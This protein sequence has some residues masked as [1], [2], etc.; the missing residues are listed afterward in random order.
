MKTLF[1]I[2]D[3]EI[4]RF[5]QLILVIQLAVTGLVCLAIIGHPIPVLTQIVGFI[6][7]CFIP[8]AV[9]L[10]A[11]KWHRLGWVKTLLYSVGL[12]IASLMFLGLFINS[13]YP[14]I[15]I[16][17]PLSAIPLIVS[18][19]IAV[20][21]LSI[22]AYVRDR[23]FVSTEQLNKSPLLS[24][25]LL[26]L[27]LLP[28]LSVL[29]AEMVN[30]YQSNTLL[31]ILEP[32]LALVPILMVFTGFIPK[33]LY[34]LAIFMVALSLLLQLSLISS[35]LWGSD[36][37]GEYAAYKVVE[38]NSIWSSTSLNVIPSYN[39]A[40]S[41]TILPVTFAKMLN[42]DGIWVFKVIFPFLLSLVPLALYETI[43]GQFSEKVAFLS[44]FFLMST[45]LFY[46]AGLEIDKQ[47]V[48]TF[49]LALFVLLMMDKETG[50]RSEKVTLLMFFGLALIVSHYSTA[51]LFTLIISAAL[52]VLFIFKRKTVLTISIGLLFIIVSFSWYMF[53]ANGF[54]IAQFSKQAEILVT[55]SF[56]FTSE[57]YGLIAQGSHDLPAT[58]EYLYLLSQFLIAVGVI[59]TAWNWLR[60]KETQISDEYVVLA[61]LV[62]ALLAAELILSKISSIIPLD[63][64]YTISLFF[65]APFGIVGG[66]MIVKAIS[67]VMS[68]GLW[69]NRQGKKQQLVLVDSSA[70]PKRHTII[71]EALSIFFAIFLLFN[72]GFVY[73]LVGHPLG[74]SFAL[75]L[76]KVDFPIYTTQEINSAIWLLNID[77]NADP[78]P[79]YYDAGGRPLF[80]YAAILDMKILA[81]PPGEIIYVS[82]QNAF[83]VVTEIPS[84]SYIYLRNFNLHENKMLLGTAG[85]THTTNMFDKN[86][87]DLGAFSS[88]IANS[89]IVYN[90][91]SSEV[92][93]TTAP[94]AP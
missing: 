12:S 63:R 83:R 59:G 60:H 5:L 76:E 4:K 1:E 27:V 44:A 47:L 53:S 32:L 91:G 81:S 77:F 52:I 74:T 84:G 13:V 11:F 20:L 23:D 2:N 55:S 67:T 35:Y 66:E 9:I 62:S 86:I 73:E 34:P 45:Y 72:D 40:L 18:I 39:T 64:I 19:T 88:T 69:K 87:E 49:F 38:M 43:R 42:I 58:L 82:Q 54:V 15:G 16:S 7:L 78:K 21:I 56:G 6:Y 80:A 26:F 22:V 28:L 79:I 46:I 85:L 8:G 75:S 14:Y 51:F 41:I 68:G 10:R 17:K 93:Y 71:L 57:S 25:P 70:D 3:W 89:D 36:I 65:L 24:P 61:I 30:V 37:I 92:L 31:M 90:N 94:Y 48:A 29:G 33:K 50:R